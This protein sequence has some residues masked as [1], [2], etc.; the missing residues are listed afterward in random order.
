[1]LHWC[2][3]GGNCHDQSALFKWRQPPNR[4]KP[5]TM[6]SLITGLPFSSPLQH[7]FFSHKSCN[8][9]TSGLPCRDLQTR[10]RS[11]SHQKQT[12]WPE[13]ASEL[14]RPSDRRFSAKLVPTFADRG[15]R[16][17]SPADP[18]GRILGFVD[19]SHYFFSQV[20]PQ[21]YPRGWVD[22]VPDPLLL[23]KSGSAGNQTRTSGSVA[24]NPDH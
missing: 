20:A 21:L 10:T 12:P 23:R 22:P 18:Y 24:R 4:T 14:H 2:R 15:C 7:V 8:D 16:V 5:E 9:R 6:A 3:G 13:S 1:M 11:N 19:R 17:V